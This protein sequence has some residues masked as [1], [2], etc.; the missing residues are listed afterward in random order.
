[1]TDDIG[2]S[3]TAWNVPS[4]S[5]ALSGRVVCRCRS[6]SAI[7]RVVPMPATI[8]WTTPPIVPDS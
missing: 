8:R 7:S 3:I 1:M 5:R 4:P 6:G 2:R